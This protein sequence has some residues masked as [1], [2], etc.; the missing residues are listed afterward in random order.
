[1]VT[2]PTA[3][4]LS[5]VYQTATVATPI[6]YS[7][8]MKKLDELSCLTEVF[9]TTPQGLSI[10]TYEID[11]TNFY[12]Y[13]SGNITNLSTSTIALYL[14]P[15]NNINYFF[16]TS[17]TIEPYLNIYV[18]TGQNY[19]SSYTNYLVL[20]VGQDQTVI[21]NGSINIYKNG[22]LTNYFYYTP[23]DNSISIQNQS[24]INLLPSSIWYKLV[25]ANIQNGS[26]NGSY[27]SSLPT[28]PS[29]PW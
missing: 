5:P 14:L 25:I 10:T 7:Y 9:I 1:M 19:N 13:L 26:I 17:T 21:N 2:V 27:T 8:Y 3:V 20:G 29:P 16:L 4:N 15:Y 12:T 24:S 22:F 28:S 11:L 23:P 18:N 6:T